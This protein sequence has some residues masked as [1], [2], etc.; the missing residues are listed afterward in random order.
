[1]S[2]ITREVKEGVGPDGVDVRVYTDEDTGRKLP[3]V[4]TVL[5]TREEDKSNLHDW[6]DRNDGEGDNAFHKHLFWYKRHRGT[7]AHF[8]ALST[9]DPDLEWSEDEAQSVHEI[10][11]QNEIEVEDDSPR[12]VLY[13]VLKSQHAVETWGE[14]YDQY[15]P[16]KDHE[17]YQDALTN[18]K[19]R[20]VDFFV[21]TVES[22]AD[23]LDITEDHIIAVEEFLFNHIDGYAGQVDLV[24]RCPITDEVV[25]ADLKTSSGCYTKHKLQGAAYG[26]SVEKLLDVD[27]VDRTEVWRVHPDTGKWAVHC[28]RAITDIHSTKYWKRGYHDL[29]EEFLELADAFEYTEE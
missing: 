9:L 26:N 18:Q 28:N 2:A 23:T 3:S 11:H 12:E 27:G 10:Y 13:S 24:Y 4:T 8:H 7:L 6:Q 20:D 29:L 5:K 16:Y 14:F 25:V 17:F 21:E 15:P 22:I 1:M 19:D